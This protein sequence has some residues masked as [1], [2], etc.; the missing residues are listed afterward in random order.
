MS[1]GAGRTSPLFFKH[2]QLFKLI[3]LLILED[4]G[5]VNRD[6]KT[7]VKK[8]SSGVTWG[9]WVVSEALTR[10][11]FSTLRYYFNR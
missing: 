4:Q 2:S 5:E 11:I 3:S 10:C 9:P 7:Y 8:V 1:G 6:I